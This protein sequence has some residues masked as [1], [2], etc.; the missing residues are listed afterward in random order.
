MGEM[1]VPA[2]LSADRRLQRQVFPCIGR[3]DDGGTGRSGGSKQGNGRFRFGCGA[4]SQHKHYQAGSS[5]TGP[6]IAAGYLCG[7]IGAAGLQGN[8]RGRRH[9]HYDE[10]YRVQTEQPG[11]FQY[12]KYIICQSGHEDPD[13]GGRYGKNRA[14]SGNHQIPPSFQYPLL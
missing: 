11:A 10:H 7:N 9:K 14:G 4:K 5:S 6:E 13:G 12:R 1:G 3:Y 8:Y 2:D